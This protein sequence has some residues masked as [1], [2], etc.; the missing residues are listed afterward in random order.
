MVADRDSASVASGHAGVSRVTARV[1]ATAAN[2]R[3]GTGALADARGPNEK[4]NHHRLEARMTEQ[5]GP[6]GKP[7]DHCWET[8]IQVTGANP[9]VNRGKLNTALRGI[10]LAC[11]DEGIAKEQIP[12]EIERRAAAYRKMFAGL[13]LTPMALATHWFRVVGADKLSV[14]EQAL[15][16]LRHTAHGEVAL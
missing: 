2:G 6:N 7:L 3:G 9:Y 14:E 1:K 4:Q 15:A 5:L 13:T 8:L 11:A 16:R 10:R 12:G